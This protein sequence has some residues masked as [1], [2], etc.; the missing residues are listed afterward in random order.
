MATVKPRITITLEPAQHATLER[1]S[2]LQKQPMSRIVT[3]LLSEVTPMLDKVADALDAAVRSDASVR[4]QIRRSA[5]EAEADLKPLA[6]AAKNQ[7]DM[8]IS[9]MQ[10]LEAGAGEV[11]Q[12]AMGAAGDQAAATSQP[13]PDPRPVITGV[14]PRRRGR[15]N[16][17][18]SASPRAK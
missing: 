17:A 15:G 11:A 6:E 7:M 8:F 3:D 14:N 12:P 13:V 2:A 1:L 9:M 16:E 18:K 4:A 5:E 10:G